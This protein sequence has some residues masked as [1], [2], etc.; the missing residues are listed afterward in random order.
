MPIPLAVAGIVARR[1]ALSAARKGGRAA[2]KKFKTDIGRMAKIQGGAGDEARKKISWLEIILVTVVFAAPNDF[3]DVINL[4]GIGKL[5]TI[6]IEP[7]TLF[8]LFAWFWFRVREKL[9]KKIIKNAVTFLAEIIPVI[10]LAPL[11]I[12]LV[13]NVKTGWVDKL[14]AIPMKLLSLGK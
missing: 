14:L 7:V 1:A 5:I 10:G 8:F 2:K 3:L 4:T 11:W 13:I 6:F 12:I 9:S